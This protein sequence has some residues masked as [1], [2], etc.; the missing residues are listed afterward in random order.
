MLNRENSVARL[1]VLAQRLSTHSDTAVTGV[2]ADALGTDP[3]TVE[4]HRRVVLL[5]DLVKLARKQVDE[6]VDDPSQELYAGAIDGIV[7]AFERLDMRA[8]W[9]SYISAFNPRTLAL[10]ETCER[11]VAHRLA[12]KQP[13]EEALA[14]ILHDIQEAIHEVLDA[15]VEDEAKRLLLEMLREV[16]GALLAYH[17]SGLTGLRRAVERTLGAV[18]LHHG[19]FEQSRSPGVIKRAFRALGSAVT[20]LKTLDFIAQLP[21]KVR[22]VLSLL[23]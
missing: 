17:V 8:N 4:F 13:K 22:D 12:V 3:S 7:N 16:E 21:E 6:L 23:E 1:R 5:V 10:L 20:I 14:E 15:D 19:L 11:A 18:V 9:G 2:L